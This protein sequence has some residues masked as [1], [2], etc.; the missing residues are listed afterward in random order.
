MKPRTMS[1]DST[2]GWLMKVAQRLAGYVGIGI[3]STDDRDYLEICRTCRAI[4]QAY[5]RGDYTTI[6]TTLDRDYTVL[7]PDGIRLKRSDVEKQLQLRM[8]SQVETDYREEPAHIIIRG[9]RAQVATRI[10]STTT[11]RRGDKLVEL[12]ERGDQLTLWVKTTTGWKRARTKIRIYEQNT[13]WLTEAPIADAPRCE[14]F[15]K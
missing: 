1:I 4:S 3:V 5:Q 13:E 8:T 6:L 14:K 10:Y 7:R 15:V 9:K 11:C 12:H 2:Q